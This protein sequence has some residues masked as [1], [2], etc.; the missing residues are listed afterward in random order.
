M[1]HV[2]SPRKNM[3]QCSDPLVLVNKSDTDLNKEDKTE[4]KSTT[5]FVHN[6]Q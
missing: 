4:H 6:T 1:L 5:P 3:H 2:Y